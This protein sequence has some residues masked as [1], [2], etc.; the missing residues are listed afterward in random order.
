M[1]LGATQ[2]IFPR[3]GRLPFHHCTLRIFMSVPWLYAYLW[4]TS[5]IAIRNHRKTN[6]HFLEFF[7]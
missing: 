2:D 7:V 1:F 6:K 5:A 3:L 4:N